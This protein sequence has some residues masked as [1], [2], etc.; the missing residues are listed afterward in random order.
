MNA[1]CQDLC[2]DDTGGAMLGREGSRGVGEASLTP[3]D[4]VGVGGWSEMVAFL[5]R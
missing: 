1:A 2:V 3:S 4:S 5:G